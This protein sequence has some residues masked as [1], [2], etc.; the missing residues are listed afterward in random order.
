MKIKSFFKYKDCHIELVKD[1]NRQN[2]H[3]QARRYYVRLHHAFIG[4]IYLND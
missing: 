4:I 3:R 2:D 1:K